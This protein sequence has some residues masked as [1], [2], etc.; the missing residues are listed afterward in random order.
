MDDDGG[1]LD[2][3]VDEEEFYHVMICG[4]VVLGKFELIMGVK[5]KD[6]DC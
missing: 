5:E 6:A 4:T 2:L 1:P 3:L